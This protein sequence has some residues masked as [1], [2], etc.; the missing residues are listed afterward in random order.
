MKDRMD[1]LAQAIDFWLKTYKKTSV[2]TATYDR[3]E[4]S[5]KLLQHYPSI[6]DVHWMNVDAK[7]IQALLNLM[8]LD[9]Y[10]DS[11][12]KKMRDLVCAFY[13][14]KLAMGDI[15]Y[16]F[17]TV[18]KMPRNCPKKLVEGYINGRADL[19]EAQLCHWGKPDIELAV[20]LMHKAGLRIGEVLALD[21]ND[22]LWSKNA[23]RISKTL[24]FPAS[25]DHSFIQYGAKTE[26][27]NR[28]IP[29]PEDILQMFKDGIEPC[30]DYSA[31]RYWVRKAC[32]EHDIRYLGLHA[33]RHTFATECFHKGCDVKILS[34]L[35]GHADTN[36]TYNTY[37]HLYGDGL[38]EMRKIVG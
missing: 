16:P 5:L 14:Y 36:V 38:E 27:S 31:I 20:M 1:T 8:A 24:V 19:I 3:L 9:G 18:V 28:I 29:L 33:F 12:I 17:Y 35:L 26:S 4:T 37:I 25:K 7:A 34:K 15:Q 11:T 2:K 21:K 23:V 22:I 13:K 6:A 32:K 30:K 10:S